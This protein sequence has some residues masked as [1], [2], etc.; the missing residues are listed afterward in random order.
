MA[1]Q[2]AYTTTVLGPSVCLLSHSLGWYLSD[3]SLLVVAIAR[4]RWFRDRLLLDDWFEFR[5]GSEVIVDT[6]CIRIHVTGH[7]QITS[8]AV[9]YADFIARRGAFRGAVE[10]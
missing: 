4:C 5:I 2:A 7:A 1:R 6:K 9:V 3:H 8:Q 10:A